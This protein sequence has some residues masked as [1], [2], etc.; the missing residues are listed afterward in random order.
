MMNSISDEVGA[1]KEAVRGGALPHK[2]N[3]IG[4][5]ARGWTQIEPFK[6]DNKSF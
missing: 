1:A 2:N 4:T 5:A 3:L 6:M